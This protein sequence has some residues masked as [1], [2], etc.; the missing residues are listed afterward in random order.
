MIHDSSF[1]TAYEAREKLL[2]DEQVKLAHTEQKG[3]EKGIEQD[4]M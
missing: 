3:M 4:K 1:R 2:L